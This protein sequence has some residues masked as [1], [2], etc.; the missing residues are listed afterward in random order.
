MNFI[1]IKNLTFSYD[2]NKLFNNITFSIKE[3]SLVALVTPSSRGKT[4]L[5]KILGG[6]IKTP[7][8]E[9]TKPPKI[10]YINNEVKFYCKTVLEELLLLS[11][12]LNKLKKLLK[13]FNLLNYINDSPLSLNYFEMQKLNLVKAILKKSNLILFDNVFSYMDNYSKIEYIGLLKKYQEEKNIT[14]IFTTINIEDTIFS[15]KIIIIDKELLYD[16]SVDKIY[17]DENI[18]KKSKINIPLEHEL[19]E[20][21]KLY[22]IVDDIKYTIEEVVDEI[23]K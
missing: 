7:Y 17:L 19:I 12:N 8:I 16:G 10:S 4:T 13:E 14:I 6:Y 15:D 22:D 18:L 20:K 11:T 23:C 9:Y 3:N 2:K 1:N 5:L 21:L